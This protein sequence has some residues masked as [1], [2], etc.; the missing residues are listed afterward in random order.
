MARIVVAVSPAARADASLDIELGAL[1]DIFLDEVGI[2]SPSRYAVPL[3]DF[4]QFIVA[5]P[6]AFGSR[7]TDARDFCAALRVSS[8]KVADFGV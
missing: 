5:I 6:V 8:F 3:G 7:K 1:T 2:A 4:P